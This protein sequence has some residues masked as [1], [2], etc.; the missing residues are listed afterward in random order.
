[1]E[2]ISRHYRMVHFAEINQVTPS[3]SILQNTGKVV[4]PKLLPRNCLRCLQA[5]LITSPLGAG[6]LVSEFMWG[7]VVQA[8][9]LQ[10]P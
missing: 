10:P 1:M 6:D 2:K 9:M 4:T 7:I 3:C 8:I 5:T